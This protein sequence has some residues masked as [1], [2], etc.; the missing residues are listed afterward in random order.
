M[1]EFRRKSVACIAACNEYIN[2]L[3]CVGNKKDVPS[4]GSNDIG[5]KSN[6]EPVRMEYNLPCPEN[7]V[8]SDNLNCD[9]DIVQHENK[10]CEKLK[11][12]TDNTCKSVGKSSVEP[13]MSM[14]IK[15]ECPSDSDSNCGEQAST[16]DMGGKLSVIFNHIIA[17]QGSNVCFILKLNCVQCYVVITLFNCRK[18]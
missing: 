5:K 2:E 18:L 15:T 7:E 10:D 3:H 4:L 16:E 17:S 11:I 8:Q 1:Y 13:I 14:N 9:S 12:V 6:L